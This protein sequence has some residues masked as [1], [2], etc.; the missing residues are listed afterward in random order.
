MTSPGSCGAGDSVSTPT[1]TPASSAT[2]VSCS[3]TRWAARPTHGHRRPCGATRSSASRR[4]AQVERGDRRRIGGL[5]LTHDDAAGIVRSE[6][7]AI[8]ARPASLCAIAPAY[9]EPA[10]LGAFPQAAAA[11]HRR[12]RGGNA[13]R[14]ECVP[15]AQDERR[16]ARAWQADRRAARPVNRFPRVPLSPARRAPRPGRCGRPVATTALQAFA[17]GAPRRGRRRRSP[18]PSRASR[19]RAR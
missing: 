14:D 16:R 13:D 2:H 8:P 6:S 7:A 15:A 4:R 18:T 11:R 10:H 3:A 19:R 1:T 12:R 9:A 5:G 17:C